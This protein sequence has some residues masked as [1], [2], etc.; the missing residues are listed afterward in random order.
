MLLVGSLAVAQDKKAFTIDDLF[1]LKRLGV[2]TLSPDG[3]KVA[4][5]V[6][7]VDLKNN[8]NLTNIWIMDADGKNQL[9]LTT[10]N[11]SYAPA[12]SP[13]S[14]YLAFGRRGQIWLISINGGEARQVS[15]IPSGASGHKWSPDG[16][17]ILF[18]SFVLPEGTEFPIDSIKYNQDSKVTAKELDTLLYRH[19]NTWRDDGSK[20]HLFLL[21]LVSGKHRDLMPEFN[22]DT[23]PFP[24]GG[25]DDYNFSPDGKEICFTAKIAPDPAIHTNLDLHILDLANGKHS[26]ITADYQGEDFSPSYSPDG[27]YIAFKVMERPRFESDQV[28]IYLYERETGKRSK[29][30]GKFDRFV[31][32]FQW[33]ADSKG[34]YGAASSHGNHPLYY[35]G[36]DGTTREIV[37][38]GYMSAVNIT[39][40]GKSL[41]YSKRSLNTPP[42]IKRIDVD[43]KNDIQLTWFN[44]KQLESIEMGKVEV[45]WFT[46]ANGDK[47]Q[48]YLV[49]PP[50][51]KEGQKYPLLQVIHG[52]PQQDYANLWTSGWNAQTFAGQGYVV[53]LVSFHGTPGFGQAFTDAITKNWGGIPYQDLMLSTDYLIND[54]G[55]VDPERMAAGGGSYGG[56]MTNWIATQTDRFKALVTHAGLFN[57]E[58]MYG[59]TEELWF[60][61]WEL[62]G[63]YWEND[64]LYK[65]WSP[66]NYAK[67]IKTPVLVIHGQLDFRVP[68]TQGMEM[69]TALQRQGIPSKFVYYP[70]EDHWIQQHQ[71]KYYWYQVFINWINK[72]TA[73]K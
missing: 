42:T 29:V 33:T 4:F 1:S 14:K 37:S 8:R 19:W 45:H 12:W 59:A 49:K 72:Y 66:H 22:F 2:P 50:F 53:A 57:L 10:D 11:G 23:P 61:E 31:Q 16:K 35:F 27:K 7:E 18:T 70:D 73:A 26:N 64:T 41:V 68:V 58:S 3:Q 24:F 47:V 65:K 36:L 54:L 44:K 40:D 20:S 25:S 6:T 52:G 48:M 13:C 69:F 17:S 5:T 34:F 38:D 63:P 32:E 56:Y 71:N 67:N 60:P 51:F 21:D 9:Q 46:G 62:D 43:G 30:T 15:N 39:P 55:I 28:E